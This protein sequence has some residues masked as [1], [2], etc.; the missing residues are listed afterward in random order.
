MAFHRKTTPTYPGGLPGTHDYIN[1]PSLNGDPGAPAPAAGKVTSGANQGSY[2]VAFGENATSAVAN[3]G[4]SALADNTDYLDD[5]VH[6]DA[7][8]AVVSAAVTTGGIVTSFAIT[9]TVFVAAPGATNDQRTRSGLI[10]ILD[11]TGAPLT[12][13]VSGTYQAV[14]ASLIHDGANNNVVGTSYR[15]NPTV[16]VSPSIPAST[17]YRYVYYKRSNL[18]GQDQGALTRF[19]NGLG[20]LDDLSAFTKSLDLVAA[21]LNVANTWTATQS[22]NTGAIVPSLKFALLPTVGA[23]RVLMWEA[24]IDLAGTVFARAYYKG[25]AT[26]GFEITLNARWAS[27]GSG[28]IGV[29]TGKPAV[30][31][32]FA[33]DSGGIF[34]KEVI[35]TPTSTFPD[36]DWAGSSSSSSTTLDSGLQVTATLP[37]YLLECL[38]DLNAAPFAGQYRSVLNT[39][40]TGVP[41]PRVYAQG[42]NSST[43]GFVITNNAKWD[44]VNSRWVSDSPSSHEATMLA[45]SPLGLTFQRKTAPV[46]AN[47]TSWSK[48]VTLGPVTS[49]DGELQYSTVVT[50]KKLIPLLFATPV[51]YG[52]TVTPAQWQFLPSGATDQLA[53]QDPNVWVFLPVELPHAAVVTN[54][55]ICVDKSDASQLTFRF[56]KITALNFTVGTVVAPTPVVIATTSTT[57]GTSV[58][59]WALVSSGTEV[60]DAANAYHIAI[61]ASSDAGTGGN[62]DRIYGVE[63]TYTTRTLGGPGKQ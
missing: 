32:T 11:S 62:V 35:A 37:D 58:A 19:N 48:I 14:K 23:P 5:A 55:K 49:G 3:R 31:Y 43:A 52:N 15:V 13:L 22:F 25:G 60:I 12:V 47:F 44:S 29:D 16:N 36:S 20:G 50:K 28:W 33:T 8:E 45:V 30:R 41:A 18:V 4:D 38:E 27:P 46:G 40:A 7:S 2:F 54:I 34:K 63:V 59:T 21:K 57:G 9:G 6:K 39:T 1:T 51:T 24:P 42:A 61:Q 26:G 56:N 10:A 53:A 17:T